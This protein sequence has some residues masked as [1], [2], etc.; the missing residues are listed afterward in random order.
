MH[1]KCG[2]SPT[3]TLYVKPAIVQALVILDFQDRPNT[4]HGVLVVTLQHSTVTPALTTQNEKI[5]G[6]R[7]IG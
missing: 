4:C 2:L 1:C 7:L 6:K 3:L 5:A